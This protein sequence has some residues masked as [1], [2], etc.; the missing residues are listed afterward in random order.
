MK[1]KYPFA[2]KNWKKPEQ[3]PDSRTMSK[4][5]LA[6]EFIRRNTDY[7]SNYDDLKDSEWQ[8]SPDETAKDWA[9]KELYRG[10]E[11]LTVK[12]YLRNVYLIDSE[13]YINPKSPRKKVKFL[14]TQFLQ[15]KAFPSN[16]WESAQVRYSWEPRHPV[17]VAIVFDLS[18]SITKQIAIA[19]EKLKVR[20]KFHKDKLIFP[21]PPIENFTDYWRI[22]DAFASG[23]GSAEIGKTLYPHYDTQ[24]NSAQAVN[25]AYNSALAYSN[26]KFLDILT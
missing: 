5:E 6:W 19:K 4:Q 10:A 16:Y 13:N 20:K 24:T 23:H 22:L 21:R 14:T 9:D 18:M 12:E 2:I 11:G 8:I 17:E 7:Q 1:K 25:E 15:C 3:Y 26:E